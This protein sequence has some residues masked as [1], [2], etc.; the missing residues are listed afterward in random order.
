MSFY[1]SLTDSRIGDFTHNN[2]VPFFGGS[3]KQNTDVFANNS[4]LHAH[5][6]VRDIAVDIEHNEENRFN[7]ITTTRFT[8]VDMGYQ[9]QFN[10][11]E[12][13]KIMNNVLPAEQIRVGQGSKTTD[14][15][16]P[17]GG[18]HHDAFRDEIQL[19]NTVD[20]LRVANK[21]QITYEG[22]VID[23][24]KEK[25]NGKIGKMEKNRVDTYYEKTDKDLFKTTGAYTKP[26]QHPVVEVKD[27]TRTCTSTEYQGITY[28]NRGETKFAPVREPFKKILNTFGN[29]NGKTNVKH[30]KN[31]DYG[32]TNILVYNNERDITS[33]KTYE[34]NLTSYVKSMIAPLTDSLKRTNK[35]HFVK[36]GREFG[37]MQTTHPKKQTIH[38]PNDVAKTTLKETAI[39]DTRTGNF[40]GNEKITVYD[41]NDVARTTIKETMIHDSHTGNIRPFRKKTIVYD[42][43]EIAKRTV[44]ETLRSENTTMNLK[45]HHKQ[46]IYDPNDI[47][48]TTIKETTIDNDDIGYVSGIA[49]GDG[50]LTNQH[51][52]KITNKQI[53]S[54]NEYIG[55]A[56]Q[57]N[58]DGYKNANFNAKITNKQ[59]T[60]DNDYY[61]SLSGMDEMKSYDDIYNE[62]IN[63]TKQ[64]TL[65]KPEPTQTGLKRTSGTE[66][67][68]LTQM[69]DP[70]NINFNFVSKVYQEPPTKTNM[71]VTQDKEQYLENNRLDPVIMES[72]IKNPYSQSILNA[73]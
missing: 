18:F 2:M 9:E 28:Q 43:K 35:E 72:T 54:D 56:D 13:P 10:R 5:T 31:D 60:S 29:R 34:G 63:N 7:D 27:T 64:N 67:V 26:K 70:S 38:D 3:I 40:K 1:S 22:R 14:P 33:T 11:I 24:V 68:V 23:G 46:T 21:P 45:G 48:R 8:P 37:S 39:H 57:A 32:K 69:K 12:Q 15:S 20:E 55:N 6:G 58:E 51:D 62:I 65:I 71:V 66:N 36:N 47:A 50:H 30:N 73:I 42:P 49:R 4:R 52:A 17:S 41:P 16:K 61:G 25:K 53:T 44:R 19:Y 59:I